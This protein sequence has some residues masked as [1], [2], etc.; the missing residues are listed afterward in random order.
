MRVYEFAKKYGV[1]NREVVNFLKTKKIN[2]AGHMSILSAEHIRLLSEYV[3]GLKKNVISQGCE[4]EQNQVFVQ[5][6][7][8]GEHNGFRGV[9][10][11]KDGHFDLSS[12]DL[13]KNELELR[14][15]LIDELA[16]IVGKQ[17]SEVI[18]LLLSWGFVPSKN[19]PLAIDMIKRLAA[20]YGFSWVVKQQEKADVRKEFSTVVSDKDSIGIS[21]DP[22]VVIIG[23]VD[24]GKTTLLDTIRKTR[25]ALKEKGGITQHIGAYTVVTRHGSI[26]FIDTP[27]HEA[28]VKIR[29]RGLRVADIAILVVAADDGVM[30]QTIEAIKQARNAKMVVIVAIN[31]IDRVD[32]ARLDIVKSQ[33]AQHGLVVE[34]WGGDVM[35][36]PISAKLGTGVDTLLEM[37]SLQAELMELKTS[38]TLPPQ[39]Y[40]LE[41][42]LEKGRGFVGTILL[43]QGLLRIGDY[44]VAGSVGGRVVGLVDQ[45]GKSLPEVGPS[46]PVRVIGFNHLPEAG[47]QFFVSSRDIVANLGAESSKQRDLLG[48]SRVVNGVKII[49]RVDTDSTRE[50]LIDIVNELN[51]KSRKQFDIV[52]ALVGPVTESDV[53]QAYIAQADIIVLHARVEPKAAFLAT[54][55]HVSI[56]SFDIIYKLTEFLEQW[57]ASESLQSVVVKKKIGTAE[58]LKV[59][60]IKNV[61]VV[62]GCI[63]RDGKFIKDGLAMILRHGKKVGEG[64]VKSLQ[65]EKRTLK[66][67][68]AGFECGFIIEG[69]DT[70]MVGD[71]VDCYATHIEMK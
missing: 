45:D 39:G 40:V 25:V 31:K 21:R 49:I 56:H 38:L 11:E 5:E 28:F 12:I 7:V 17:S 34:D 2:I 70:W 71:H 8:H 3:E 69:F 55:K 68:F 35:C 54:N 10:C 37:V 9:A 61:G 63:V 53:E 48:V 29:A 67:V 44:F 46:C 59:F 43:Q 6:M 32:V 4:E 50:A 23:H 51:K 58:V 60:D 18:I 30:P 1:G 15:M 64:K 42:K 22:I 47:D 52:K 20:H 13:K 33:L 36:L 19:Q 66:E 26:V 57:I 62:A 27:G 16:V 41:S 24:H 14:S 65:R